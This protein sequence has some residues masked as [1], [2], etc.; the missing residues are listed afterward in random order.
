MANSS[1]PATLT[2]K[3]PIIIGG[4]TSAGGSGIGPGT[5]APSPV[6]LDIT[7]FQF[8]KLFTF[9]ERVMIDNAQ[10]NAALS[11][12]VKATLATL[13]KDLEISNII[14]LGTPDVTNG[15]KFLVTSGFI[16][17]SRADRILANLPPL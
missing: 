14:Q 17:K 12:R 7:K 5:T 15:V 9:D 11:G 8:R 1:S 3:Q 4:N 10:Y 2:Q 6:R 13:M 16:T